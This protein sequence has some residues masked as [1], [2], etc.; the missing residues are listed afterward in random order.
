MQKKLK[1]DIFTYPD[2]TTETIYAPVIPI[3]LTYKH[4]MGK[5]IE[6]HID[7]GASI[8]LFPSGYART[9]FKLKDSNLKKGKEILLGGIGGMTKKAYGFKCSIHHPNF[10]IKD[11][12]IYFLDN[13]PY[14]LLG[15]KGFIDQFQSIKINGKEKTLEIIK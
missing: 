8:N 6:S 4:A 3:S 14:P 12:Y 13:Q 15:L 10:R 2:G 7:T 11:V 5:T 9:F 1:E